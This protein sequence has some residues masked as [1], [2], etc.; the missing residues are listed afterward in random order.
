MADMIERGVLASVVPL[1][2]ARSAY[3]ATPPPADHHKLGSADSDASY[4]SS[5]GASW[6]PEVSKRAKA[7]TTAAYE[8][9]DEQT[10]LQVSNLRPKVSGLGP[11]VATIPGLTANVTAP[12]NNRFPDVSAQAA[13]N[14]SV[15]AMEIDDLREDSYSP[16]AADA[17]RSF[18]AI[19]RDDEAHSDVICGDSVAID[20]TTSQ[21]SP[22]HS[23][24]ADNESESDYS[25]PPPAIAVPAF[26]VLGT[27]SQP[28][29]APTI[30]N[31]VK[32]LS[33]KERAVMAAQVNL[34]RAQAKLELKRQ[35]KEARAK[36]KQQ[37]EADAAAAGEVNAEPVETLTKKQR[38]ALKGK[39]TAPV[40]K[41]NESKAEARRAKREAKAAGLAA[42]KAIPDDPEGHTATKKTGRIAPLPVIKQES[43]TPPSFR[44]PDT[45]SRRVV[46][47]D[48]GTV[49]IVTVAPQDS[50]V[51]LTAAPYK[52][53]KASKKSGKNDVHNVV[54]VDSDY[55]DSPDSD[56]S[57]RNRRG[58][59]RDNVDLRK[60]ASMQNASR[61]QPQVRRVS[62]PDTWSQHG[63]NLAE[64][65]SQTLRP[66]SRLSEVHPNPASPQHY[67]HQPQSSLVMVPP[68]SRSVTG[69]MSP[70]QPRPPLTQSILRDEHGNEY[71]VIPRASMADQPY[72][73]YSSPTSPA[74]RHGAGYISTTASLPQF[75]DLTKSSTPAVS[76][77]ALPGHVQPSSRYDRS[78]A[79]VTPYVSQAQSATIPAIP[80]NT[81]L[82]PLTPYHPTT[83]KIPGHNE[84]FTPV[85][86]YLSTLGSH[87]PG[88]HPA[89]SANNSATKSHPHVIDLENEGSEYCQMMPPPPARSHIPGSVRATPAVLPQPIPQSSQL[90]RVLTLPPPPTPSAQHAQQTQ[91]AQPQISTMST[92]PTVIDL[93][94][95]GSE[96]RLNHLAQ[97]LNS[98]A[99][100]AAPPPPAFSSQQY[101][102]HQQQQDY[103]PKHPAMTPSMRTQPLAFTYPAAQYNQPQPQSMYNSHLQQF[104]PPPLPPQWPNQSMAFS[105]PGQ[106]PMMP[107]PPPPPAFM[108]NWPS[109]PPNPPGIGGVAPSRPASAFGANNGGNQWGGGYG[110][111]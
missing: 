10:L 89:Y 26:G 35:R 1:S 92:H 83:L 63:R 81:Y 4:Y 17:F 101:G 111:R 93:E 13:D 69:M 25:P 22:S 76:T 74:Y 46:L 39:E 31:K 65:F 96:Y 98:G 67:L 72:S 3:Q 79:P 77:N 106:T 29:K 15:N 27:V 68:R 24:D 85:A 38:R 55:G 71:V 97:S 90:H 6:T 82:P 30:Q 42:S 12:L 53:P 52:K 95:E 59:R 75:V 47:N 86:P 94:R 40:K 61:P 49:S 103:N 62:T 54:A 78:Y 37:K 21:Q 8:L 64:E 34:D 32:P 108:A 105:H 51:P 11:I 45:E 56:S 87:A 28:A 20:L 5:R 33:R 110:G 100:F 73:Q 9:A 14:R 109:L 84:G 48:D 66:A 57:P 2:A 107:P 88:V 18:G 58:R 91:F 43:I 60:V 102:G 19:E 70:A 80:E 50:L 16:P 99:G 36:L 44:E 104:P 41:P 23:V 7:D